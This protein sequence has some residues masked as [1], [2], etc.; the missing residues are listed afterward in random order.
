MSFFAVLCFALLKDTITNGLVNSIATGNWNVKRFHMERAGVT[1]VLS[2]LS[3]IAALG[4]V[5]RI[6]S[7][8]EKTRKVS[9]P[10]SLQASQ[11]GMLCPSDTPE[12]ESCG[13]VKNLAL[14]THV[15]T[16]D[17]EL[18]VAR[19][20]FNLGVEDSELMT[21]EE[22]AHKSVFL[23]VINGTVYG[24]HQNPTQ[25]A[26]DFRTLR[27]AGM[28]PVFVSIYVNEEQRVIYIA[29]D[30]G[31]VTRPLIIVENGVPRITTKHLS[32]LN[33]GLRNFDSFLADGLVE[34]IDVNEENNTLIALREK[35]IQPA[36][37]H[38]EVDPMTILGVVAGLI[39][40]PHHNQSPRNTYQCAMGKQAIGSIAHNQLN[41]IDTLLYLLCYPQRPMVQSHTIEMV[42][43]DKLPAGQNASVFVMSYSG[44]DIEDAIVLNKAS[45]DRGFGMCQVLRKNVVSMKHYANQT[46]DRVVCP[47]EMD[48]TMRASAHY[49][50]YNGLDR[51][52]IA[53]VSAKIEPGDILVN[54][55]MP[56]NTSDTLSNVNALPDSEYR[57]AALS[58][59]GPQYAYVDKV[60][61]SS[62]ENDTLLVK[63]L[64]RS[65]RRPEL[66]DKFSSRHGQKGV[67]GI[68]V[69]QEDLPFSDRGLYPDLVMN[70]HGF[71]SRM[72]VGKMIELLA[73]KA[74]VLQV[75]KLRHI[76]ANN[77]CFDEI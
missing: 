2:R 74:G 8:F 31:R 34:Y 41:R 17:R 73:G 55:Q 1:Q 33:Q 43:F 71:P 38:L 48:A 42:G 37:T 24:V 49:R 36:T 64:M 32:E 28:L 63:V 50:K 4:M 70:P 15:T 19:L 21:G 20:A 26:R 14:L 56:K 29:T 59:K 3:F 66:G 65:T 58:Y 39:P 22:L 67:C 75:R 52:G 47:P 53:H 57:P 13:L 18:P 77:S 62:N 68:I 25:F 69:E 5:T 23:V 72:T 61:L 12:G 6:T 40:Y 27:R 51:D 46:L 60:L 45:L 54:K 11:W 76:C 35:D 10:R 9:G 16:D 7:Q 30:G 44:Y